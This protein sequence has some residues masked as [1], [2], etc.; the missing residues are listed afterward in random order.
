[1]N[2]MPVEQSKQEKIVGMMSIA[3]R[4]YN[5]IECKKSF[6]YLVIFVSTCGPIRLYNVSLSKYA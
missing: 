4:M 6:I 3:E 1:M 5:V 2:M